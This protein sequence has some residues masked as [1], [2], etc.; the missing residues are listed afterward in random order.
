MNIF[1]LCRVVGRTLFAL[2]CLASTGFR[3]CCC[4]VSVFITISSFLAIVAFIPDWPVCEC[5]CLASGCFLQG[6]CS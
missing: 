1:Q 5:S 4:L 6:M 2:W 3:Q